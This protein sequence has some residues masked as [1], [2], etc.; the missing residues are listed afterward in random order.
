MSVISALRNRAGRAALLISAALLL[1]GCGTEESGSVSLPQQ[2]S[3]SFPEQ[4]TPESTTAAATE[5]AEV[6][7][8]SEPQEQPAFS[9]AT[10]VCAGDNLIHS[11][12]YNQAKAR[13]TDGGYDF[14]YAYENVAPLI[15]EADLAVLNQETIISDEFAPSNYPSFCTPSEMAEEMVKIGFDAVSLSNNHCLDKGEKG[16]ASTLNFWREN[17]PEIPVYGAYLSEEDMNDIRTLEVNGITFAFLG[18]MEHT[19]MLSLPKDSECRLTYLSDEERMERQ[20]KRASEIADCVIV[21]VHFGIEV[22]NT[23]SEQQYYFAQKFADWG[24]DII[25]GTQPHTI[26]TMEYLDTADGGRAFVFYCLGNFI[27]AMDNPYSMVEMLGRITVTKD[28]ATGEITLSG[29]EAVPLINHYDSGY[30]NVRVYP[31]S[32]YTAE[33]AASHG[34]A[35][36]S[37]EFFKRVIEENI[38]EEYRAER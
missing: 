10:I 35:G 33:L 1:S 9:S 23:V 4:T 32:D 37:M 5:S 22:T 3:V 11:P 13:S 27:S 30:R 16:L 24:A 26:Q 6:P 19:N 12:I 2:E 8:E 38:P 34:C 29:A 28:N 21:S 18:Y 25:I 14:G 15:E 36:T 20:I 17:Y 7:A 31:F